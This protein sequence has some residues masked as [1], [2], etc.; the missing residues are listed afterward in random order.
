M[1]ISSNAELVVRKSAGH[2]VSMLLRDKYSEYM[3]DCLL[4]FVKNLEAKLPKLEDKKGQYYSRLSKKYKIPGSDLCLKIQATIILR[5]YFSKE[6]ILKIQRIE[7][8][9]PELNG[10]DVFNLA[11]AIDETVSFVFEKQVLGVSK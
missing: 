4:S 1:N 8:S 10:V 3:A 2:Y 5:D 7:V 6:S 9:V 11:K